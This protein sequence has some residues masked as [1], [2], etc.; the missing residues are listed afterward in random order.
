MKGKN[1]M[2]IFKIFGYGL[3]SMSNNFIMGVFQSFLLIFYTDVFGIPAMAVS[4]IFLISK[5]WDAVNDP[6]MGAI[7]DKSSENTGRIFYLHPFHWQLWDSCASVHRT[8][9]LEARSYM[10]LLHTRCLV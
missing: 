8:S 1:D 3:G 6:M 9:V 2:G 7:V 4:V 5:I 10:R